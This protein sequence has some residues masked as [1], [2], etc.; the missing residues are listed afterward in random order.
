MNQNQNSPA[1]AKRKKYNIIKRQIDDYYEVDIS[2]DKYPDLIMKI[3]CV[4]Y[5]MIKII[6]AD[7]ISPHSGSNGWVYAVFKTKGKVH[8][9]SRFILMLSDDELVVDHINHDTL[10]NRASNLRSCTVRE[11]NQNRKPRSNSKTGYTGVNQTRSGKYEATITNNG[12]TIRLGRY[13]L[14][15]D[16]VEARRNAE[17]KYFGEFAYQG[18]K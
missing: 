13:E 3:D 5:D 1:T 14:I 8:Q 17:N 10:D 2:T 4:D 7:R 11:N 18:V 12:K 6:G 9:V 15:E 16:A